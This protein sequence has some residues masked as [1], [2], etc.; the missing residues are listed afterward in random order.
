MEQINRLVAESAEGAQQS[1]KACEQL[2]S[3]A[4][5]LQNLVSRFKLGRQASASAAPGAYRARQAPADPVRV[6]TALALSAKPPSVFEHAVQDR[7]G[8]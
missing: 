6:R 1:A 2:S 3:L 5:E 4:L 8:E 7:D